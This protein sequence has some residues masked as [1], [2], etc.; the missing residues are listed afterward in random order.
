MGCP[1]KEANFSST[2]IGPDGKLGKM[3]RVYSGKICK[4]KKQVEPLDCGCPFESDSTTG[5][6]YC[7]IKFD[8]IGKLN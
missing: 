7:N 8:N 3:R 1:F 2:N 5:I 6:S 4:I